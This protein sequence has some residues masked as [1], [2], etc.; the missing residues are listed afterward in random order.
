VFEQQYTSL[1]KSTATDECRIA[2]QYILERN[3]IWGDALTLKTVGERPTPIVFSEW[4]PVNGSMLKRRDFAFDELLD[5][6][7]MRDAQLNA[8]TS[9]GRTEN[10][11]P[12]FLDPMQMP[13]TTP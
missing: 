13:A 8:P 9:P 6:A 7:A 3:I 12:V 1:F 2:V 4:S 11:E 10:A 5:H